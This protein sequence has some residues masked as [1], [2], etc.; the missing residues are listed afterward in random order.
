MAYVLTGVGVAALG[1]GTYFGVRA[2]TESSA[3]SSGC[4][5]DT[6]Q[7]LDGFNHNESA[8]H[9]ALAADITLAAGVAAT[10][11]GVAWIVLSGRSAHPTTSA[12]VAPMASPDR[13][14]LP[15]FGTF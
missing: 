8:R 14:G 1:V 15:V 11:A 10:G 4:G 5:P 13:A 2:A 12:R 3:A 6:C 7:T 9:A